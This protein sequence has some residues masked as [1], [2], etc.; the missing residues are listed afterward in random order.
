MHV[1]ILGMWTSIAFLVIQLDFDSFSSYTGWGW[2]AL[3]LG[4][5]TFLFCLTN[6]PFLIFKKI[7]KPE[8]S[9]IFLYRE[10]LV[11]PQKERRSDLHSTFGAAV[12]PDY[13]Q[14]LLIPAKA[15]GGSI[16]IKERKNQNP[17]SVIEMRV[18]L[19]FDKQGHY[20]MDSS[21]STLPRILV[22]SF[23]A[24]PRIKN[25]S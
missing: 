22:V 6:T 10:L 11:D 25:E 19:P 16:L 23:R 17:D 3:F 18:F 20:G 1:S 15:N 2:K 5:F 4:G 24:Q 12:I 13:L 7:E 8:I 21:V 9:V 14:N